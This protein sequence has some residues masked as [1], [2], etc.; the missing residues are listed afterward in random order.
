MAT[1]TTVVQQ[2]AD[3]IFLNLIKK[4]KY[5]IIHINDVSKFAREQLQDKYTS[6]IG[7][8]VKTILKSHD[9]IDFFRAGDYIYD[10]KY[11]YSTGE[12]LALKGVYDNPVEAK[13]KMGWFSWQENE[14]VD[15][16]ALD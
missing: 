13:L 11:Y 5:K 10:S 15:W 7:V 6:E 4:S 3:Y 12:W 14:E 9:K 16:D 8:E 1:T 2:L